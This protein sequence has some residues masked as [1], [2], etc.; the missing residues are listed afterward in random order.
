MVTH[1]QDAYKIAYLIK[2][3]PNQKL[4]DILSLLEMPQIDINCGIWKAVELSLI[5]E[6]IEGKPLV[7]H[8]TLDDTIDI[9]DE[10]MNNFVET[11]HYAFKQLAKVET[12]FEE[13]KLKMWC[14][15]YTNHD[16]LIAINLLLDTGVIAKYSLL[17]K[18]IDGKDEE[19]MFYTLTENKSHEWGRKQFK[20]EA[21]VKMKKEKTTL[22]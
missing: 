18:G 3:Y 16:I 8:M 5:D 13:F 10:Y 22:H 17:T 19:Y 6:P 20:V 1:Y 12:D 2:K 21:P 11:I 7:S 15:G 4:E 14:K 9:F